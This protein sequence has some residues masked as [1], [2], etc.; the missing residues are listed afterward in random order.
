MMQTIGFRRFVL[1]LVVIGLIYVALL[2]VLWKGDV[3]GIREA[4]TAI[5]SFVGGFAAGVLGTRGQDD[6]QPKAE[7]QREEG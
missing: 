7:K 1:V 2:G 3:A 4:L 5:L 6:E